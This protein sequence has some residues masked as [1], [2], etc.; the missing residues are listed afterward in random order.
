MKVTRFFGL[1]ALS[2]LCVLSC[3]DGEQGTGGIIPDVATK[4][5]K[6]SLGTTPMQEAGSVTRVRGDNSL[7]LVLGEETGKE[8]CNAGTRTGTLTDTQEDAVNDICVF[9]FGNTDG[10]LKY[11]EYTSLMDGELTADISLASGVGSCTVYVLANVGNIIRKVAYGS[12]VADFKKLAAEVS[13]GKG[14]GQNLPMCGYKADFNSEAD[15]ASLTVSLTRAVAKVSLNLT[16]PNAGDV[17]TVTSVRLMNVAKKLYYVESATTA[18]TAAE[19]TTY[20]SD[21]TK[22]IAWYVP[23]NKAGSNSLTDWKERYED[24]VPATATYI[25]IEGSYTPKGGIARDVAYTIYLGAGDKAG[26]FNVVRNTKYTINA[27]IKGTNMNDGRVLVGKD[28]SAAGTQTANCY[29]VNTTDANKWY[30]FKATIRGNGAA[31]SAQI[32]Y[33]GTDIPA[34]DRIAPDN[35]A[36]VWETREGDKAPTLDYVGYSRNGYIVF[37]LGEAT[38]GNAVVAAKNGATTLWSWHIWTTAAFDRNGIK[39][40]T[41]ETRPR[42]GLASY[43]DITKREFKMMDR[44]LGAASGT[45]T[46]VAE[47][48]IKTYGVYFQFGRKDP[49]PAAGVMVRTDDADI[50]PVY[51]ANGNK[52]LK[53][54]NQIKNSTITKGTDQTAV[55]LQ[56]AYAVENP[57]MFILREDGDK[58]IAYGGD[59]T[60]PSYNWIFAAHPAKSGV[61]G[62]VPWKASNKLWGS[63]LTNESTGLILETITDIKKTIYD[64]CPY[65][66]H[67]P[68]QDTWTNFTTAAMAYKTDIVTEYNVVAADKNNQASKDIGFADNKFEVWGRRFFAIGEAATA[69]AGNVAFYP[70]AGYRHGTDGHINYIG[71]ACIVWAASPYSATSQNAGYWDT[72]SNWV[73]SVN[74]T[75]R[76]SAFPVRCVQ[77]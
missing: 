10:K 67:M 72:S 9:Q 17:F 42:N 36:L 51:D 23:E 21:N 28:L 8:A 29:V 3:T 5:V 20:T 57:L 33:T 24:N 15:N 37:K 43:A 12:A 41:Y 6:L 1:W 50:V 54:S 68:P 49:F 22:S 32:S 13:S 65:G 53:N 7:D 73:R 60:N 66:Y 59:G 31:T 40:Q 2:V 30:R 56:L 4:P 61:E 44:N 14:T 74:D 71:W 58:A 69:D 76:S 18:P 25:L 48:A 27:A 70:A 11:S 34:N 39:V 45:A 38:E 35:A 26:D 46:K 64:P 55:K 47:E 19:L 16:T 75:N 63:G 52:I 77:D 62:S